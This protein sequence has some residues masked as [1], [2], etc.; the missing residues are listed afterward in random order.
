MF[1]VQLAGG[2]GVMGRMQVMPMGAVRMMRCGFDIFRLVVFGC[3]AMMVG[4]FFVMVGR[5]FVMVSDLI[6]MRHRA[7]SRVNADGLSA[8]PLYR[9]PVTGRLKRDD[10][11]MTCRNRSDRRR[12]YKSDSPFL[13]KYLR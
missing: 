1:G 3:L 12:G 2:L 13:N 11:C 9:W 4:G 7:R 8:M 6:G 10:C 5:F